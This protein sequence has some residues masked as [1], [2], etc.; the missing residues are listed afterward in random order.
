[1]TPKPFWALKI[2]RVLGIRLYHLPGRAMT[3]IHKL[4]EI[5]LFMVELTTLSAAYTIEHSLVSELERMLKEAA[6]V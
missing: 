1:M 6:V 4:G 5:Y 3:H 2:S